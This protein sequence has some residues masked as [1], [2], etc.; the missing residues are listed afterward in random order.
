MN[1]AN[2]DLNECVAV[3]NRLNRMINLLIAFGRNNADVGQAEDAF[4]AAG[5]LRLH[6]KALNRHITA[7]EAGSTRE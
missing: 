1:E 2:D 3:V 4:T 6:V 5:A 7:I